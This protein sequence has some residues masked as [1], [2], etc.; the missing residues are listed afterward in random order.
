VIGRRVETG[1]LRGSA[2]SSADRDFFRALFADPKVTATIFGS[3]RTPTQSDELLAKDIAHWREHGFG[4]WVFVDRATGAPIARGG[5]KRS[6]VAG[7]DVVEIL[8]AV[9]S[10]QWGR[11][12]ATEIAAAALAAARSDDRIAEVVAFTLTTNR[13]SQRVMQ[14]IGLRFDREIEHAGLPHVLYR[15]TC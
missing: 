3:P 8:Y 5:L 11:G 1:R 2:P 9:A 13:A 10:A 6:V 12:Y 4:P 15:A 14:K 7:E